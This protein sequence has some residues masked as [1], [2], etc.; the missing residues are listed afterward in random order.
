[1]K[2]RL[3]LAAVA[4]ALVAACSTLATSPQTKAF[5]LNTKVT[6]ADSAVLRYVTL[7]NCATNGD[8]QPC[9]KTSYVK[10]LAQ[11]TDAL[12]KAMDA[13]V[14]TV[15]DPAFT[16][17]GLAAANSAVNH[18]LVALTAILAELGLQP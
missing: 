9:S 1:M 12:G 7:P 13:Y 3:F 15:R 18:A 4:F 5:D 14:A 17:G 8:L 10:R 2:L 6:A 16:Q 11:A